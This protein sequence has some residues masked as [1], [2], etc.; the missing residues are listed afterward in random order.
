[1][2]A[3]CGRRFGEELLS[4]YLDGAL[5]Q[6]E[7]QRVA[8]HLEGCADCRREVDELGAVRSA[9]R[10]TAFALPADDEWGELPRTAASRALRLGGW[11]IVVVWLAVV[12][13]SG[14]VELVR[15]SVPAWERVAIAGAV[16]GFA[17][18][19]L[20]VL[21]DRLHDLRLDRYRRVEK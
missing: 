16:A 12:L 14:L 8:L 4:G 5:T 6:R 20:S 19:L 7:R 13:G 9:A 10:G 21:L 18:L 1:M 3:P 15:S 2:S 11:T 17:L